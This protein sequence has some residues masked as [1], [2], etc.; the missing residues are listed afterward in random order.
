[1]Y[2]RIPSTLHFAAKS[3]KMVILF[4]SICVD[5]AWYHQQISLVLELDVGFASSAAT[6][7]HASCAFALFL[8]REEHIGSVC[9][10]NKPEQPLGVCIIYSA[11][12]LRGFC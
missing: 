2:S 3:V 11:Q 8:S 1:M 6:L 5:L 4:L 9:S 12:A 10:L 7:A